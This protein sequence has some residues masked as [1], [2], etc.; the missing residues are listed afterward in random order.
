MDCKVHNPTINNNVT[1]KQ[2]RLYPAECRIRK[3]SYKGKLSVTISWSLN[4]KL[5]DLIED[6]VGEIPIMVKS[7]RCNITG[8]GKTDLVKHKEDDEEFGGYFIMNG[9]EFL[10]RTLIAQRRNYVSLVR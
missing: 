5:Q 7:S 3:I 10:I 6:V 9:N 1:F 2:Q 4:G 8:L